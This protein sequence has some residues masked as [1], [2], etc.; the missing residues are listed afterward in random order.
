MGRRSSGGKRGTAALITVAAGAAAAAWRAARRR[1]GAAAGTP[2]S[3]PTTWTCACGQP[4][5]S[6][7]A[8]RHRVHWLADAPESDPILGNRCPSCDRLLPADDAA[9]S[10]RA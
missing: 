4:M 6:T 9:V 5:R 3:A 2:S 8:G 7:G 10:E 1:R